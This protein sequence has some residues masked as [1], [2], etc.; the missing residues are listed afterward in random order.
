MRRKCVMGNRE[1]KGGT[2]RE[3]RRPHRGR[4]VDEG[5]RG[6]REPSRPLAGRRPGQGAWCDFFW[7]GVYH[8]C[9]VV[10]RTV[11]WTLCGPIGDRPND[12]KRCGSPPHNPAALR[13]LGPTSRSPPGAVLRTNWSGWPRSQSTIESTCSV[14]HTAVPEGRRFGTGRRGWDGCGPVGTL[15]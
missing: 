10:V 3:R 9:V 6:D 15:V 14:A 1:K 2:G 11:C 13:P 5:T 8:P 7:P 4:K 12:W